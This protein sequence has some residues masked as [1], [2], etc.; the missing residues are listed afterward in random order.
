VLVDG[1]RPLPRLTLA[2][3]A[4]KLC[5]LSLTRPTHPRV[6]VVARCLSVLYQSR[7]ARAALT[8]GAPLAAMVTSTAVNIFDRKSAL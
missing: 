1:P 4:V 5:L 8:R 2:V 6:H 7:W 3:T